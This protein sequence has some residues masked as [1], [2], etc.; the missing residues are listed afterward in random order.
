[1]SSLFPKSRAV[2]Q[3]KE[4][5][6]MRGTIDQNAAMSSGCRKFRLASS[7]KDCFIVVRSFLRI[8]RNWQTRYFEVVV[9]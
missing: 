2:I 8:W 5:K 1:M 3:I 7:N 9:E 6:I 4:R